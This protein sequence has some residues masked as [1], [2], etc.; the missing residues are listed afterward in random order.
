MMNIKHLDSKTS[1]E[2][3][4]SLGKSSNWQQF[5]DDA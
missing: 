5:G 3:D 2:F 4:F 1:F